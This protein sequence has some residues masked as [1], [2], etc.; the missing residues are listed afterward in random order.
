MAARFDGKTVLITGA[1]SGI[2]QESA[3]AFAE[4][5]AVVVGIDRSSDGL[6]ETAEKL[7]AIG[8]RFEPITADVADEDSV[9]TAIDR[10]KAV[11]G[12]V[13]CAFNNAGITQSS[14]LAADL[15]LDEWD[16]VM[17]INV[18]GVWLC[19]R[20]EIKV[21][22]TQGGGSI[23]NT[24][25]FLSHHSMPMQTAYA[26]SKAAL[27]GL[28]KNAAI[29]YAT[30]RIRINAVAPGGIPT[31]MMAQS[32]SGLEREQEDAARQAIA[33]MHPMKRLGKPREIAQAVMFLSSDQ[34]EFVTGVCLP[35]DGG[36][37]AL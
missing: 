16:R 35:V 31:G 22:Q 25:S 15:T 27:V 18:T 32:L 6:D 19:M 5:G 26:A 4:A 3:L 7:R 20:A 33:D 2:G 23:V 36:W 17:R 13:D 21:M 14:T 24:A 9:A 34:A 30:A 10:A 12:R 37:S 8:A 29:E 1:A 28:T 11:T